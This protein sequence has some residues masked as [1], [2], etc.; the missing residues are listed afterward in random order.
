MNGLGRQ[1]S[2]HQVRLHHHRVG[3]SENVGIRVTLVVS[4]LLNR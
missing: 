2:D 1:Q 4:C 3:T